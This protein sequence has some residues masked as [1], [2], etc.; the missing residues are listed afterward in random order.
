MAQAIPIVANANELYAELVNALV[1]SI[2]VK[3]NAL[4]VKITK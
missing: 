2:L 4:N 3:Y 1:S